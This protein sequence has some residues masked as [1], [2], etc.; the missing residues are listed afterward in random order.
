M[1]DHE[2]LRARLRR[3]DPAAGVRPDTPRLE[4]LIVHLT[5]TPG[6][7]AMTPT[8]PD[9]AVSPVRPHRGLLAAAAAVVAL[10]VAGGTWLTLDD[11]DTAP[12][13]AGGADTAAGSTLDLSLPAADAMAS[14]AMFDPALLAAADVAFLGTVTDLTDGEVTLAVEDWYTDDDAARVRLDTLEGPAG[15]TVSIDGVDFV[16]GERFLVSANDGA[17]LN[18]GYSGPATP[19]LTALFDD[20]FGR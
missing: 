6:G 9:T 18:C 1:T 8:R 14:C 13:A 3:L 7:S 12:T 5:Q 11:A 16:A 15:S 4:H 20:A 19:A 2:D 10:G 17:V